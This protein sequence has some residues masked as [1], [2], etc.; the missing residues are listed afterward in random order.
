[1]RE[2]VSHSGTMSTV[3]QDYVKPSKTVLPK[4]HGRDPSEYNGHFTFYTF[5]VIIAGAT[6]GLLLGYDN[7]VMGGTR[8]C[9]YHLNFLLPHSCVQK[10]LC[11][12]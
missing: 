8:H 3:E 5:V 6:T 2:A 4:V 9:H 7:G 11:I 1:M 12:R 10:L